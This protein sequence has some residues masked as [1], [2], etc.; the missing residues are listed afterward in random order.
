MEGDAF[1]AAKSGQRL[2]IPRRAMAPL[3]IWVKAMSKSRVDYAENHLEFA[4]KTGVARIETNEIGM[5]DGC[6]ME[7]PVHHRD[8][9]FHIIHGSQRFWL[10]GPFNDGALA[11]S[12]ASAR[13]IRTFPAD[14]S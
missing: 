11:P 8:E 14:A 2:E 6:Q 9:A 10:V 5:V 7:D 4:S 12:T 13:P 1:L 3:L